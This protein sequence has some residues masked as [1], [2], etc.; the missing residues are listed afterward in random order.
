MKKTRSAGGV[1]LNTNGHVLVVNQ[2][3]ASWSLPKGHLEGAETALEAA[4]REVLEEA[5][6]SELTLVRDLGSY[7]RYKIG[8]DG[9]DDTSELKVMT[10]FLFTT[11][12]G[13]LTP[14]HK[15]HPQLRWVA[16][17]GVAALLTHPKD[18]EFFESIKEALP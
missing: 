10:F 4:R 13:A 9:S 14:V 3:G 15:H 16:R 17:D 2:R 5:G 7:E 8:L 1:V 11:T 6:I 12:H 18:K